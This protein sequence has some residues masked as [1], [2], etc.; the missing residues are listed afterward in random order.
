MRG[1]DASRQQFD[2]GINLRR[3]A[4]VTIV[5]R[6]RTVGRFLEGLTI[7]STSHRPGNG[8]C[9]RRHVIPSGTER[10]SLPTCSCSCTN[11][12]FSQRA[13]MKCNS[14]L[15]M[16]LQLLP[17][18]LC[19]K[20]HVRCDAGITSSCLSITCH[21]RWSFFSCRYGMFGTIAF[22]SCA[23]VCISLAHEYPNKDMPCQM[24]PQSCLV[25]GISNPTAQRRCANLAK[26]VLM[27]NWIILAVRQLPY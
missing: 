14:V 21:Y 22:K 13:P 16:Y 18:G 6:C 23:V 4:G 17:R 27:I 8:R 24:S 26:T 11:E 25:R 12:Y 7:L 15:C 19:F 5:E 9:D 3:P 20:L 10:A 2:S 1:C